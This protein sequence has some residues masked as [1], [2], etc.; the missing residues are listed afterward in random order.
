MV[1]KRDSDNKERI[2]LNQGELMVPVDPALEG[3]LSVE[4]SVVYLKQVRVTDMGLFRV[5][6][7]LGFHVADVYLEVNREWNILTAILNRVFFN[8]HD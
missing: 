8:Y 3:R 5:R 6:D 1:Y 2:I 7:L 4:G